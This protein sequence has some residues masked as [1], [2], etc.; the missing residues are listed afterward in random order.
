MS[1]IVVA[2][3]FTQSGGQPA[4]GLA[5]ADIDLYLTRL[6]NT[7]GT[8]TVVW[9]GTQNPTVEITNCGS[10]VRLY[11][12]A[13]TDTYTYFAAAHY[14]G[15]TTLDSDY[16]MGAVAREESWPTPVGIDNIWDEAIAGHAAGG[17]FG[18]E[19]QSHATPAEVNAEVVDGLNVDAYAEPGQAAPPATS[20]LATKI[21]YLFKAWRNKTTQTAAQY[22]L[23]ND[24]GGTVDQKASVSDAA[25]TFTRDEVGSGP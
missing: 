21:S 19:I 16:V 7:L 10:Y 5:L 12:L 13:D 25:G 9:D 14:T 24:A 2:A 20:S 22:S 4:A 8:V 15:A 1:T 11:T 6:D 17:S 3:Q 18:A 23:Y